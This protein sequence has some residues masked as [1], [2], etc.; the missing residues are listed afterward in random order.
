[1]SIQSKSVEDRAR[2]GEI[3]EKKAREGSIVYLV[4]FA[5]G[6]HFEHTDFHVR[7]RLL[8]FFVEEGWDAHEPL[9]GRLL[10]CV[11][12]ERRRRRRGRRRRR[13]RTRVRRLTLQILAPFHT[14]L[15]TRGNTRMSQSHSEE[16][17]RAR[18]LLS[19]DNCEFLR[20]LRLLR[21]HGEQSFS[22]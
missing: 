12:V 17:T 21:S 11:E 2:K 9:L 14:T 15:I 8:P 19:A 16:R 3:N 7:L 18:E 10:A 13:W 6:V 22:H 5:L 4:R 20:L 1:M